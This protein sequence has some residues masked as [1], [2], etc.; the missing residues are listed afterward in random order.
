MSESIRRVI[1]DLEEAIAALKPPSER[2]FMLLPEDADQ[3]A[4]RRGARDAY[5]L[6]VKALRELKQ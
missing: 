5:R 6:C 1:T 2:E 4:Y 3:R